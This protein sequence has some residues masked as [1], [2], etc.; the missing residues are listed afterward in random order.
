MYAMV[1]SPAPLLPEKLNCGLTA[2]GICV[3]LGIA[4]L[5]MSRMNAWRTWGVNIACFVRL[6]MLLNRQRTCTT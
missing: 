6:G 4:T 3:V 1:H 2:T 5:S